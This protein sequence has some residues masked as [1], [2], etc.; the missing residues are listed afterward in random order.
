MMG[1]K[2]SVFDVDR[3]RVEQLSAKGKIA[4]T[5]VLSGEHPIDR[6]T[7]DIGEAIA[8]V[9]LIIVILPTI[10]H[11]NIARLAAPHL[12]NDQV[13]IL[14]P[15]GTGGALEFNSTIRKAGCLADVTVAETNSMI[16]ACRAPVVGEVHVF[17]IKKTVHIASLPA[18]RINRVLDLTRAIYP[19]FSPVSNVL[20]TSLNNT[21]AMVHPV[22]M[23]LNAGRVESGVPFEYYSDGF[24]ASV[25][26]VVESLDAER[27]AIGEAMEIK[28]ESIAE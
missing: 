4:M 17:G 11:E 12:C 7:N 26:D 19:Q 18:N 16:Y 21:T 22:P 5:G 2:V 25:S 14:N 20:Y 27:L 8:G 28:L 23:I 15:G 10:Y 1:Y 9:K 13:V 6:V 24:T 3:E